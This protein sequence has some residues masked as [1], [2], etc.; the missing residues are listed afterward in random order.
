MV[1]QLYSQ[2]LSGSFSLTTN[3]VLPEKL[4]LFGWLQDAF[5]NHIGGQDSDWGGRDGLSTLSKDGCKGTSI[6]HG[7]A[8]ACGSP[9]FRAPPTRRWQKQL[10]KQPQSM[11]SSLVSKPMDGCL[12]K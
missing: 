4:F 8:L 10:N 9:K 1:L 3:D 11:L 12:G 2:L 5:S 6:Q 7:N